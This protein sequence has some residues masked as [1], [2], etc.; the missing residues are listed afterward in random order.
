MKK[1][2]WYDADAAKMYVTNVEM[3]NIF[4]QLK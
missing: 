4:N 3:K 1:G 2:R